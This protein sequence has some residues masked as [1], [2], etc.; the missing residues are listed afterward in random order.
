MQFCTVTAGST[1]VR[2]TLDIV[3]DEDDPYA[4]LGAH[5]EAGEQFAQVR[6]APSF[7]LSAASAEAWVEGGFRK[8]G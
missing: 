2:V 8:P 5:D 7:K 3:P 4:L 1:Q 6:V